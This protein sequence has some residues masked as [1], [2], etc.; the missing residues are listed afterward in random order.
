M[1]MPIG[2]TG[3]MGILICV[4]DG[5]TDVRTY[6]HSSS[7]LHTGLGNVLFFTNKPT[8]GDRSVGAV[9]LSEKNECKGG[10]QRTTKKT[11]YK[12]AVDFQNMTSESSQNTQIDV[13]VREKRNP[14]MSVPRLWIA[15]IL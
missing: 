11:P 13:P 5:R 1:G 9:C 4:C 3:N 10:T 6:G 2:L 15:S 12:T 7:A 8:C 14:S